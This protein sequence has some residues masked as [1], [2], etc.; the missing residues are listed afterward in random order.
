MSDLRNRL[1]RFFSPAPER[2]REQ[3]QDRGYGEPGT[4]RGQ[5]GTPDAVSAHCRERGAAVGEFLG[6]RGLPEG[7]WLRRGVY[8]VESRHSLEEPHGTVPLRGL[9]ESGVALSCWGGGSA[10]VFF[11][12]ETTGLVGGTGTYAFLAGVGR[13]EEHDFVVRQLF[14]ASPAFE[15]DW[16]EMLEELLAEGTSLV[17]YN[18]R[19]YDVPLLQTRFALARRTSFLEELP[20]LDLLRLSRG[21]WKGDL[22]SFRL[23]EVEKQVLRFVRGEEDV[24]GA[25]V[26]ELYGAYLRSGNAA[27]LDGVFLHNRWDILSLAALQSLLGRIASEGGTEARDCLRAGRLWARAGE[28]E[29]ASRFWR[30]AG[31]DPTQR[32]EAFRC[33]AQAAARRKEWPVAEEFWRASLSGGG[34]SLVPLVELSKIWEHRLRDMDKAL[35]FAEEALRLFLG[36]RAF[37]PGPLWERQRME[38]RKRVERLRRRAAQQGPQQER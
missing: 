33:L 4:E 14:L 30:K 29:K 11:D 23:V 25:L 7:K 36:Q 35:V 8:L 3:R 6:V 16:L 15:S 18:G 24:P 20:H 26:P 32:S 19:A 28:T 12:L 17:S 22:E 31:E 1:E 5:N 10:P 37:L 13:L 34:F 27:V 38:L 21:V 9:G 2:K